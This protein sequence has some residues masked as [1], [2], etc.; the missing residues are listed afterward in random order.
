MISGQL[1]KK[2]RAIGT[3]ILCVLAVI[4]IA[5]FITVNLSPMLIHLP[6]NAL[7]GI[8]PREIYADYW[9]LLAYL[10]LPW[11]ERLQL[12]SI[13]L[14][15]QAANHFRDV[16]RLLLIGELTS[17]TSLILALCL[18]HKQKRQGQLWRL[19]LPLKWS[20]YQIGR[21]SCRERV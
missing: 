16:R 5:L 4:G 19:L 8:T 12:H 3:V 9:R 7:F 2:L 17:G 10:E 11:T 13:P 14:T 18:L 1:I 6:S 21:A 15:A 20:L